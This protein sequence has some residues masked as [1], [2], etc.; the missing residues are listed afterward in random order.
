MTPIE[1]SLAIAF[2]L[3]GAFWLI[4]ISLSLYEQIVDW[5]G[6]Y[7]RETEHLH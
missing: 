4:T 1:L 3:F 6:T 7:R 5:R 2:G